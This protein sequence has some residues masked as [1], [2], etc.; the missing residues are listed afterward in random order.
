MIR[1][2]L[3]KSRLTQTSAVLLL[4][5]LFFSFFPSCGKRESKVVFVIGEHKIR[6]G[7]ITA[8]PTMQSI[9]YQSKTNISDVSVKIEAEESSDEKTME[10]SFN[11]EQN[12]DIKEVTLTGSIN[13]TGNIELFEGGETDRVA[14]YGNCQS[15]EC[16]HVVVDLYYVDSNNNLK[17][18]Q[19]ETYADAAN[20]P[21]VILEDTEPDPEGGKQAEYITQ[22]NVQAIGRELEVT[23]EQMDDF[24]ENQPTVASSDFVEYWTEYLENL[25]TRNQVNIS[26]VIPS[27]S[28]RVRTDGGGNQLFSLNR[29]GNINTFARPFNMRV[30]SRV[31]VAG[32]EVSAQGMLLNGEPLANDPANCVEWADDRDYKKSARYAS[33]LLNAVLLYTGSKFKR[34]IGGCS[35]DILVNK[36]ANEEGGELRFF[37][38]DG[39]HKTH[40]NGLDVDVS[41][42]KANASKFPTVVD[43]N[44]KVT[45]SERDSMN[46]LKLLK[47]F[48]DT[49]TINR[50]IISTYVKANLVKIAKQQGELETYRE[51]LEKAWP[52]M[53]Y[54]KD[55]I[56][57]EVVCGT[58]GIQSNVGCRET[59]KKH[60]KWTIAQ[61]DDRTCGNRPERIIEEEPEPEPQPQPGQAE[62]PVNE[63]RAENNQTQPKTEQMQRV[64]EIVKCNNAQ[65]KAIKDVGP[66]E[67]PEECMPEK[68]GESEI[69]SFIQGTKPGLE[70]C[71]WDRYFVEQNIC[72]VRS[73]LIRNGELKDKLFPECTREEILDIGH[74]IPSDVCMHSSVPGVAQFVEQNKNEELCMWSMHICK[75]IR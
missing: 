7:H 6:Q 44:N 73:S 68:E 64:E 40:Q 39:A 32:E 17:T 53:R 14:G 10:V 24:L 30:V 4:L 51:T 67:D 12:G 61:C 41:Y 13:D 2:K 3:I 22:T 27:D 21:V 38:E 29:S 60:F 74:P 49:G 25:R 57:L 48:Y 18:V 11:I 42:L 69:A 66:V 46:N 56:H 23:E 8:A 31:Q 47:E 5:A 75:K 54:H 37:D 35:I 71:S 28:V 45:L 65:K 9:E 33:A 62:Q 1:D 16:D 59:D 43:A 63:R 55:H 36:S 20:K 26:P 58:F 19:T 70:L 72:R 52:D 34:L 15:S 50:F